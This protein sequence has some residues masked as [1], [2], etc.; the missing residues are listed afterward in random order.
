[1]MAADP[2]GTLSSDSP[3][4]QELADRPLRALTNTD[5]EYAIAASSPTGTFPLRCRSICAVLLAI[6]NSLYLYVLI[7]C[8]GRR[9]GVPF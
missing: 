9:N 1:V 2:D 6:A 8:S 3:Q 5:F 7:L 4:M